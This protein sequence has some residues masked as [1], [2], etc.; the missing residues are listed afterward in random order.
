M[1]LHVSWWSLV[2]MSISNIV[3]DH[4]EG[5]KCPCMHANAQLL[6]LRTSSE[7]DNILCLI[8]GFRQKFPFAKLIV[9]FS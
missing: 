6:I 4:P 5:G 7:L 2:W 1:G 8:Y 9:T 3:R